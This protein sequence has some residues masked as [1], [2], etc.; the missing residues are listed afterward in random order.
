VLVCVKAAVVYVAYIELVRMPCSTAENLASAIEVNSVERFGWK[1]LVYDQQ[2]GLTGN[3][4]Q[5]V[6]KMLRINSVVVEASYHAAT[7][8]GRKIFR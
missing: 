5:T 2:S 4:I 8:G 6:F 1:M 3:L 7:T